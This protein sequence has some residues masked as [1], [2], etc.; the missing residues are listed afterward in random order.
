MP[1]WHLRRHYTTEEVVCSG[2]VRTAFDSVP[3][4][5]PKAIKKIISVRAQKKNCEKKRVAANC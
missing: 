5:S 2:T 1:S 4:G 3:L